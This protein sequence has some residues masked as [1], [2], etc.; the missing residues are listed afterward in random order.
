MKRLIFRWAALLQI[1]LVLFTGCHPT[2]PFFVAEDGDLSHYLA[3][4]TQIEYPDLAVESLPEATQ[5]Q[6]PFMAGNNE[7]E[8]WDLSLEE[9]INYALANSKVLRT[10]VGSFQIAQDPSVQ[11]L[12]SP[13]AQLRTNLDPAIT[14]S[15]ANTQG[16]VIDQNGNRTLPRGAI[17]ANQVGGIEDALA[18]FDA[19]ASS[20]LSYNTTDRQRNASNLFTPSI[21]TARDTTFQNALSKRTATGGVV[22]ARSQTIYSANNVSTAGG[23]ARVVPSDYTQ[24]L[25]IQVQHPLMRGRGT[26]VNRIPVLLARINEDNSLNQFEEGVRNFVKDIENMYWELYCAY[27][28]VETSKL[29]HESALKV[30]RVA[31]SRAQ[32]GETPQS[33]F[34]RASAQALRFE[35]QLKA[36]LHGVNLPGGDPG[37]LGRERRLRFYMGLAPTD[38]RIIRPVD[39]PSV[40]RT[41]FDWNSIQAEALHRNVDLRTQ[42][43]VVK[44]KELELISAKN[45]ILPDVNVSAL[46]RWLGV[47]DDL[48]SRDGG[49]EFPGNSLSTNRTSAW[50]SLLGG[51]YQE[52]G[53]RVEV[54][55]NA[56]GARRAHALIRNSQLQLAREHEV[57]KD[58]ELALMATL[59][60]NY[61]LMHNHYEQVQLK[62]NEWNASQ[63]DVQIQTDRLESG[64]QQ[65]EQLTNELLQAQERRAR[66]QQE[67]YRAVCEYNK[68][69]V[70]VHM[71]KGSLLDY[72]NISLGEGPW[73]DKAYWDAT[74]RA[75]ERDAAYFL[76]GGASRPA[77]ISRGP[78]ENNVGSRISDA[79]TSDE[80]IVEE[81]S[82]PSNIEPSVPSKGSSEPV[83]QPEEVQPAPVPPVKKMPTSRLKNDSAATTPSSNGT[84]SDEGQ[85]KWNVRPASNT[86]SA[87]AAGSNGNALRNASTVQRASF[88]EPISNTKAPANTLR[89]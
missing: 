4:A 7:F 73:A 50:E 43:W 89:R 9:V 49:V 2:Q 25:E 58:K 5:A 79:V 67:Y 20:F 52:A 77:V 10:S 59:S 42:K 70:Q 75:R 16:L 32:L 55:P 72:N 28:A 8:Y 44:Q 31:E 57:L 18:E 29:A 65:I 47:G 46:Y 41:D 17:K 78:V 23:Q 66:A 56:V 33:V 21:F 85:P 69:I 88:D 60:D 22:T 76:E 51:N 13:S 12:S 11:M 62:L 53:F 81:P 40:A 19:Q 1:G 37:V 36:A 54:T 30:Y 64:V 38:G 15:T 74:E 82:S 24:I 6:V 68:S 3:T 83:P 45:Q 34:Y 86:S 63:L 14:S 35:G 27:W 87:N 80:V 71:L 48:W 61:A 26:M 39:R 84:G